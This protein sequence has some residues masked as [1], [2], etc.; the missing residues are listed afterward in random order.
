[1]I[2]TTEI[3]IVMGVTVL[4]CIAL[5]V[6]ALSNNNPFDDEENLGI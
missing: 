1:M 2:T 6:Y 3:A 4:V 5:V